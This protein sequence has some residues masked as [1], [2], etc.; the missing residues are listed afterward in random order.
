MPDVPDES[1]NTAVQT[2]IQFRFDNNNRIDSLDL[3][4]KFGDSDLF[5][6][7]LSESVR[8]EPYDEDA[9]FGENIDE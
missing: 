7:N 6:L 3:L 1:S 9:N 5:S 8:I 4:K 2:T